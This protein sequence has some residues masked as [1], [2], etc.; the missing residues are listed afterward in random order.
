MIFKEIGKKWPATVGGR[1]KDQDPPLN[2]ES[3]AQSIKP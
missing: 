2:D 3:G 1:Y